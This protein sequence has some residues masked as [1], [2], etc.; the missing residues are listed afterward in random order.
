MTS[1]LQRLALRGNGTLPVLRP[2][3]PGLFEPPAGVAALP[4]GDDGGADDAAA[5]PAPAEQGR[6]RTMHPSSPAPERITR[7]ESDTS[8]ARMPQGASP[9]SAEPV[10]AVTAAQAL[11]RP[12]PQHHAATAAHPN[13]IAPVIEPPAPSPVAHASLPRQQT[14]MPERPRLQPPA[15]LDRSP[16][17]DDRAALHR[18]PPPATPAP[19]LTPSVPSAPDAVRAARAAQPAAATPLPTVQVTIGRV[20]VR[21]TQAPA[22]PVRQSSRP[23]PT[24][25]D[26]YLRQRDGRREGRR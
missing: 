4:V 21:A 22:A 20:E 25:L 11:T 18:S 16:I 9:S 17:D 24:S 2:R 26:D 5:M 14:A 15:A 1:F 23:Q 10:R 13:V 12:E 19:A 8:I 3:L 7:D 6:T